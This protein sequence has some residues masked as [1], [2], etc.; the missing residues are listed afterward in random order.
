MD[1]TVEQLE[2]QIENNK[3]TIA[4]R[5]MAIKLAS[6]REF[7]KLILDEFIEKEMAR[8]AATSGDPNLSPQQRADAADISRAGGHLK[9]WLHVVV[10]MGNSAAKDNVE[11]EEAIVEARAEEDRPI[12]HD[13]NFETVG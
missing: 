3:Q 9:R 7:K 12:E 11:I 2:N 13:T 4:R 5:D 1:V 10:Q 8:Y 6:N